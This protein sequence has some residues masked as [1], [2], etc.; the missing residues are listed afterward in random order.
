M[1]T[2]NLVLA[3]PFI[4]L[5]LTAAAPVERWSASSTTAMSITGDVTFAPDKLTFANR[6]SLALSDAGNTPFTGMGKKV[7]AHLYRVTTPADPA[8]LRG[9]HLCGKPVTFVIVWRDAPGASDLTMAAFSGT[10]IPTSDSD[11]TLCGTFS[12]E[13]E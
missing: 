11:A 3:S 12:Y 9:N 5:L 10:K 8:L 2:L 7:A 4:V 6:A 13:V 1:K